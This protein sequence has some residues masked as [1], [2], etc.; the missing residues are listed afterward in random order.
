MKNILLLAG[1]FFFEGAMAQDTTGTVVV[2]KDPRLDQLVRKQAEINVATRR[3]NGYTMKGYRLMVLN[4]NKREEA[5]DAKTKLYTRFPSL[6][7]YLTYQ[8]PYFKVKAGNF[9]TRDEAERYRKTL[10]PYFPKGVF[11]VNDVI[12]ILPEKEGD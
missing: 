12:E 1:L 9:K 5:I 7:S 11:V 6:K 2:H 4:T 3:E 10:A 8:A